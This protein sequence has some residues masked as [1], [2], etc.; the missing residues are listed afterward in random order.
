M[1]RATFAPEANQDLAEVWDYIAERDGFDP[2]DE[3]I[4]FLEQKCT[5]LADTPGIGRVR[6]EVAQ[7]L[8]FFPVGRYVIAYNTT[9]YGIH[10]VRVI[11]AA[12]DFASFF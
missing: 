8:H 12:R 1:K 10:V 2:A 9:A 6:E 11:H 3:F 4:S 5:L 7:G